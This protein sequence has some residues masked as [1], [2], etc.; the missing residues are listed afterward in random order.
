MTLRHPRLSRRPISPAVWVLRCLL[1]MGCLWG[2]AAHAQSSLMDLLPHPGQEKKAAAENQDQQDGGTDKQSADK[3]NGQSESG[4]AKDGENKAGERQDKDKQPPPKPSPNPVQPAIDDNVGKPLQSQL[5]SANTADIRQQIQSL[6][7]SLDERLVALENSRERLAYADSLL[8]RLDDE[9]KS[10]ELRLEKAGLNLTDDYARLLRQRLDRLRRQTIAEGLTEGIRDQLSA[11]REEQLRLEEYEAVMNPDNNAQGQMRQK[12]ADLLRQ[13]HKA[14]TDHI[15]VLNEY[16]S[17]VTQLRDRVDAY[18]ELLQQ[19]LFWLPSADVVSKD[20]FNQLYQG[21]A[22]FASSFKWS[23]VKSAISASI[24]ERG[25]RM[26]LLVLVLAALLVKRRTI[27]KALI[28]TGEYVGNVGRDAF[29]MT[30]MALLYSLLLS[31]PGVLLL[32][33]GTLLVKEGNEFFSAIS[34]GFGAAAF[35]MLLLNLVHKVARQAGLGERHFKWNPKTLQGIRR[36]IP[37]LMAVLIPITI[38]MPTLETPDGAVYRD[39]LGRILFLVASAAL[40]TFAH[41]TMAAVRHR[42]QNNRTLRILHWFAVATPMLLALASLMGYHYTA[43]QLEG[44]LFISICWLAFVILLYF[45]GLRALSVRERRLTLERLL[46]QR[47][48]ERKMAEAREAAESTGEGVPPALDMPEM[49]L[50][51][52][53]QQSTSLLRILALAI[54]VTGLWFM[55][56]DVIPALQLFD[57]VTLWNISTGSGK[58]DLMPITLGDLLVALLFVAGT[59][60]AARNLPGTLEVMILSRLNLEPGSGYAITTL[61]KYVIV[62]LGASISLAVLGLQWS[63]LQ[64]LVAALGVGLGFGLQEIVANFVSGIILLFE[65]P[66]RVGDTVT[67]DGITGTVTRIR[68][69]ATTLMDWDRKEQII[70]NKTFVTQDLTNWTLSDPIT[71]VIIRVGVAY[72]SDV[73][74]VR[75]VLYRVTLDNER[76]VEDPAPAVFC[77]GLGDSSIDF[78]IRAFVRD[79]MDFMPLSHELHSSITRAL[80]EAGV[81]IPFPQRDI[82]IRTAAP[83]PPMDNAARQDSES[84]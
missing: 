3:Q 8:K 20:T 13:L 54:A 84:Q 2:T 10:F 1:L 6:R 36:E 16:Y 11:A 71:R 74:K 19:R 30:L 50:K 25:F 49:N 59:V 27:R 24:S 66:I 70:P 78:E 58:E 33:L 18:Q 15:E 69:R 42:R 53:S 79:L 44:S 47:A 82:H 67:I 83:V 68:I 35:I 81:N 37:I 41:R 51:D 21:L 28:D 45:L 29:P 7:N 73:D 62:F 40:A 52:I 26:A 77:V 14:V 38:V 61:A 76:V 4:Q 22:W 72:G 60:V 48:N 17:T 64:W 65:R 31:L 75:D 55:W 32:S 39:S 34:K 57:S 5:P 80:R 9:Y 56:K 12:R 46:E 63:K 43:V 23:A